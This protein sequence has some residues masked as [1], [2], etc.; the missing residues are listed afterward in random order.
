MKPLRPT[1]TYLF[2]WGFLYAS[3]WRNTSWGAAFWAFGGG[4]RVDIGHLRI[5]IRW[6]W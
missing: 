4:C 5:G 6:R 1:H 3:W 2:D